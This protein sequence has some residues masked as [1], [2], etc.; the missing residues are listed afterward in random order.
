MKRNVPL[1]C[2]LICIPIKPRLEVSSRQ[3][4]EQVRQ[5]TICMSRKVVEG[6]ALAKIKRLVVE[7]LP[8]PKLVSWSSWM[9][10]L[11]FSQAKLQIMF[12]VDALVSTSSH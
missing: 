3:R 6:D 4:M 10:G 11:V 12:Q 7:C 8:V 9:V 5:S 2:M 1:S